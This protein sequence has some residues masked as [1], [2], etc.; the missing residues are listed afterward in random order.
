MTGT[1]EALEEI[2]ANSAPGEAHDYN[3]KIIDED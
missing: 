2:V 1:S 3:A